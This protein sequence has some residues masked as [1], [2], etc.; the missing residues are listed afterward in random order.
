ME[1]RLVNRVCSAKSSFC[2]L[3]NSLT[4]DP[5]CAIDTR[6]NQISNIAKNEKSSTNAAFN[7]VLGIRKSKM[8]DTFVGEAKLA[9]ASTNTGAKKKQREAPKIW[10]ILKTAK[11]VSI[12]SLNIC[13]ERAIN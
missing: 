9:L 4:L 1:E 3:S 2:N 11:A 13:P 7:K 8:A 5:V 12:A 6:K 10:N